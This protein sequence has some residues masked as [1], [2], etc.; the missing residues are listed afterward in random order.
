MNRKFDSRLYA[1]ASAF[2]NNEFP[3]LS[4]YVGVTHWREN[5]ASLLEGAKK[6]LMMNFDEAWTEN[7]LAPLYQQAHKSLNIRPTTQSIGFFVSQG[8]LVVVP[9][10]IGTQPLCILSNSFHIKPLARWFS[11]EQQYRA[12]HQ[13]SNGYGLYEGGIGFFKQ[14]DFVQEGSIEAQKTIKKFIT[15]GRN[16]GRFLIYSGPIQP[17]IPRTDEILS[18]KIISVPNEL[19]VLEKC[20]HSAVLRF[21]HE[22]ENDYLSL[23][24]QQ[25]SA[26]ADYETKPINLLRLISQGRLEVLLVSADEMIPGKIVDH[27]HGYSIDPARGAF[28][29]DSLDDLVEIAGHH[30]VDVR[31]IPSDRMPLLSPVVG[32]IKLRVVKE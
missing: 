31:V 9:I 12:V 29:D 32:I 6:Q 24:R 19:D 25:L 27:G 18:L 13:F 14:I 26:G 23:L 17:S 15:E 28:A 7:F 8:S 2:Q 11:L 5:L 22:I 16:L 3:C 10:G 4:I 21:A 30:G 1:L 20:Y